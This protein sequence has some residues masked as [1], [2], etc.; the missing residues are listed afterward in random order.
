LILFPT[1]GTIPQTA[2]RRQIQMETG[3]NYCHTCDPQM[4]LRSVNK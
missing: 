3:P 1:L 4:A 2:S